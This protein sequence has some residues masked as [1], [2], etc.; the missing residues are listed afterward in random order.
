MKRL[1]AGHTQVVEGRLR[2]DERGGIEQH[3]GIVVGVGRGRGQAGVAQAIRGGPQRQARGHKGALRRQGGRARAAPG[4]HQRL[5]EVTPAYLA[6]LLRHQ[7]GVGNVL[8]FGE[9]GAVVEARRQRV[10]Q[11]YVRGKVGF[12]RA[13][14]GR[15]YVDVGLASGQPQG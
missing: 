13:Q 8:A 9:Q 3:V 10:A 11:G 5:G 12:A 2:V 4:R 15:I 7:V 6:E 1:G 14:R